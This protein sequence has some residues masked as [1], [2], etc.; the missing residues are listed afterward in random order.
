MLYDS[1]IW[2]RHF[3]H[4]GICFA[5]LI[6]KQTEKRKEIANE[7][8]C[9]EHVYLEISALVYPLHANAGKCD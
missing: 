7:K 1:C 9:H 5:A 8:N 3:S 4:S 6:V 2:K